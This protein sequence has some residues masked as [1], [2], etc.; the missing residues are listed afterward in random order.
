MSH[1]CHNMTIEFIKVDLTYH[2]GSPKN[3]SQNKIVPYA[4]CMEKWEFKST[5]ILFTLQKR[6]IDS[7]LL[8][9]LPTQI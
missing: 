9:N 1:I 2:L 5:I 7:F 3:I 6:E 4:T 8:R